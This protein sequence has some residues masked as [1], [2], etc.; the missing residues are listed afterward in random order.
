MVASQCYSGTV[1]D[2]EVSQ[3]EKEAQSL[4]DVD[5]IAMLCHYQI[6]FECRHN[7]LIVVVGV[8]HVHA[9]QEY[10]VGSGPVVVPVVDPGHFLE[11]YHVPEVGIT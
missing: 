4:Y 3:T 1:R 5:V 6:D 10:D 7:V 9:V 8:G 11:V 2:L